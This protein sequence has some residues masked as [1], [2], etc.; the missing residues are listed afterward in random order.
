[1]L[2]LLEKKI[3]EMAEESELFEERTLRSK[4][5]WREEFLVLR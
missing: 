2:F 1:M 4:E 3:S 5:A